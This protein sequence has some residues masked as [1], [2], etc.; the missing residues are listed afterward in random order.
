MRRAHAGAKPKKKGRTKARPKFREEKPE[1][2][3]VRPDEPASH[4]TIRL[5]QECQR[6]VN[7][8]DFFRGEALFFHDTQNCWR[9]TSA[10]L[11]CADD[12]PA[13]PTP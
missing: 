3:A 12:D 5:S 9:G 4:R 1:G 2:L 6:M 7:A 10:M 8:D 11:W 13:R